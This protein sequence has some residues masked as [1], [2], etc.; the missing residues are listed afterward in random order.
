MTLAPI[1]PPAPF[2]PV[3]LTAEGL[4]YVAGPP[5]DVWRTYRSLRNIHKRTGEMYHDYALRGIPLLRKDTSAL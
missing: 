4:A 1:Q 5:R 2:P 3:R